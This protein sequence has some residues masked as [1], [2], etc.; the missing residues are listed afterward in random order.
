MMNS[1]YLSLASAIHALYGEDV[2]VINRRAVSGGDCNHAFLLVLSNG[3]N[4]FM[5][6]ND[7]GN[8]SF[9]QCEAYGL[10][11]IKKAG[12]IAV[13]NVLALG[14]DETL[15]FAF[16]LMDYIEQGEKKADFFEVFGRELAS[17]H[18]YN[19]SEYVPEG[20]SFGFLQDN[21]IG[22]RPQINTPH[23]DWIS[24]YRE[25]RLAP[26]I[27][28]AA[29]AGYLSHEDMQKAETVMQKLDTLLIEPEQPSLVHGDLWGGNYMADAD[30]KPVLIDPAAYVG[31]REVDLAMSSMFGG[32]PYAFYHAYEETY[33]LQDGYEDRRPLYD[34]YQ[35]LNHLNQFGR[36]YL[37]AV[38]RILDHYS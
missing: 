2:S 30:G 14:I 7:I 18:R 17:L 19:P 38:R 31:H 13:P 1:N 34:L 15:Q 24:F 6:A 10:S 25:Y 27:K 8:L 23:K 28:D 5:K 37:S 32:F 11:A 29:D 16:L 33:P 21:I 20:F 26:Q 4:I 35:M 22:F 3:T 12:Q 36:S 9:F